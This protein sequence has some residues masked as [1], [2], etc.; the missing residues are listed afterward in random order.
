MPFVQ[1]P[2]SPNPA[3][4]NLAG[5]TVI[6]TGA[7][8]GLGFEC[9][10]QLLISH[11]STVILA[12][13]TMSKGE[14]A[15]ANL[16]AN[17]EVHRRNPDA[18]IKVLKLD[19]ED[20]K[21]VMAFADN[22]KKEILD[23]HVLLLNAGIGQLGYE[24]S[25]TGHEKVTQVNYLSNALLSLELL[26]LLEATA[27]RTG[28]ATRLSWVGSRTHHSSSLAK[29]QPILPNESILAHFDDKSKYL[30]IAHYGDTK[31]L[32]AMFVAEMA[33]CVPKEQVII[34]IMCPGMVC[35]MNG[36]VATNQN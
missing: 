18:D 22:V 28:Q 3:S 33:K 11:A 14:A 32:C 20:Y 21:S 13:R 10:R 34:N 26:P 23:L 16:L 2:V 17:P 6:I 4:L 27:A 1:P 15:R 25:V 5:Q 30:A 29:K 8:A 31:L 12:V 24:S 9:A 19:M 36:S 35:E 7:N